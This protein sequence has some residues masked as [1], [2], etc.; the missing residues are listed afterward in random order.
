MEN[1]T[2]RAYFCELSEDKM[3]EVNGGIAPA[4][5]AALI[6]AGVAVIGKIVDMDMN[7]AAERGRNDAF[8]D[9]QK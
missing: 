6:A 7:S 4:V 1:V 3:M 9:M 8:K 2:N 5:V